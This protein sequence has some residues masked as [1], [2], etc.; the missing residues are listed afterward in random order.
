MLKADMWLQSCML[1]LVAL[2]QGLPP[3]SCGLQFTVAFGAAAGRC[4]SRVCTINAYVET[5]LSAVSCCLL[6]CLWRMSCITWLYDQ[7]VQLYIM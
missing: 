7:S 3:K 2:H 5:Q 1:P 4:Y 6:R